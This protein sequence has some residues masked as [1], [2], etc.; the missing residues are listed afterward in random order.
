MKELMQYNVTL[1]EH[2]ERS[3]TKITQVNL[4]KE[5]SS[6]RNNKNEKI[7]TNKS[8]IFSDNVKMQ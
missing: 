4:F 2:N 5:G 8:A 7:E 3:P 6:I 1:P